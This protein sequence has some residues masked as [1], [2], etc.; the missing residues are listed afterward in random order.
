MAALQAQAR[1]TK[2]LVNRVTLED[3]ELKQKL[4]DLETNLSIFTPARIGSLKVCSQ[5][6][7]LNSVFQYLMYWFSSEI[8][9]VAI[10]LWYPVNKQKIL[11]SL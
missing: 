10:S 11:I 6:T 4:M 1:Q 3:A 7:S 9:A 2:G 8:P 5:I